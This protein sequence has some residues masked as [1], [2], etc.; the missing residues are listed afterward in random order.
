MQ[1]EYLKPFKIVD[2]YDIQIDKYLNHDIP[3]NFCPSYIKDNPKLIVKLLHLIPFKKLITLHVHYNFLNNYMSD[4]LLSFFINLNTKQL[5]I[6]LLNHHHSMNNNIYNHLTK[7]NDTF[8]FNYNFRLERFMKNYK[9]FF[10][11][12]N[13]DS[14][15]FMIGDD[16]ILMLASST[17]NSIITNEI[18]LMLY[19]KKNTDDT[20]ICL[21]NIEHN[22]YKYKSNNYMYKKNNITIIIPNI[23]FKDEKDMLTNG[24]NFI[25]TVENEIYGTMQGYC[26]LDKKYSELINQTSSTDVT[27]FP[28]SKI[29]IINSFKY[30][31]KEYNIVK[32]YQDFTELKLSST[33]IISICYNCK[34]FTNVDVCYSDY[35]HMCLECA[36]YYNE[37]KTKTADLKGTVA[38]ITGI[39]KKI[40]LNIALKLLRCG[41]NVI[42]TSRY[43]NATLYNYQIQP[44]YDDWKDKLQIYICDFTILEQ[45]LRMIENVKY[46]NINF[47]ISNACQTVKP[48]EQYQQNIL[49]LEQI[50]ND[51]K[52]IE[53]QVASS[54][55]D[56]DLR[57]V[58]KSNFAN[59]I[60]LN[61][62]ND[63]TTDIYDTSWNKHIENIDPAEIIEATLINQLVPTLIINQLKQHLIEPCFIIHVTAYE[64]DFNRNNSGN[65]AHTNMCKVAMEML[66]S[67]MNKEN[68]KN[69]Y[70][71]SVNPGF[72]SGVDL[73]TYNHPVSPA[74][75]SARILDPI[76]QHYN[77]NTLPT[78]KYVNYKLC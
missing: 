20:H 39:R 77:N 35:V 53:N 18:V 78:G 38:F 31:F 40:G 27:L 52:L 60:M 65:H 29:K 3:L 49:K 66:I 15:K 44:D 63:V 57:I 19:L 71:Y 42:G 8:N 62:F 51:K 69:L 25:F 68:T 16:V 56:I 76:L 34:K 50:L 13:F 74:D 59:E 41:A 9:L 48:S 4:K 21:N 26:K 58:K 30:N 73:T 33:N 61:K 5:K 17:F 7:L 14:D 24:S 11:L 54:D 46:M 36:Q 47:I 64:G 28:Y 45:V 23:I 10:E 12:I 67:T 55:C 43:Y 37:K 75:G 6:E 32:C 22:I 70:C 1:I 72:V 2:M